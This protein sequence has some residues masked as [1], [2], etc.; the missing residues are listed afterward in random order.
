[1]NNGF[2]W[3][4]FGG[5]RGAPT[6]KG[7]GKHAGHYYYYYYYCLSRLGEL[8]RSDLQRDRPF[9]KSEMDNGNADHE[10]HKELGRKRERERRERERQWRIC[11]EKQAELFCEEDLRRENKYHVSIYIYFYVLKNYLEYKNFGQVE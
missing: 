6:C 2:K 5:E 3:I 4:E 1:M 8:N 11:R 10:L 7:Q 9:L